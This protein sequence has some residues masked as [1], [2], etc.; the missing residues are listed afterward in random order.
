MEGDKILDRTADLPKH[1][2]STRTFTDKMIGFLDN[3]TEEESQKPFFA[4]LP[5]TAPHWP[6]QAPR[7]IIE[8]YGKY[9]LAM[10]AM[11]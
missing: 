6:L 4:Y 2:Y 10:M 3:R 9:F 7:D 5:Y 8:K 11:R 1:F